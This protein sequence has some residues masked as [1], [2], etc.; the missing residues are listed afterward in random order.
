MQLGKA[1]LVGLPR[2]IEPIHYHVLPLSL[3]KDQIEAFED[4]AIRV[5]RNIQVTEI[6]GTSTVGGSDGGCCGSFATSFVAY[7]IREW[8]R[9]ANT[10]IASSIVQQLALLLLGVLA[11]KQTLA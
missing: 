2:A 6:A 4:K 10:D 5:C 3:H 8:P 1:P 9:S 7:I 11:Q